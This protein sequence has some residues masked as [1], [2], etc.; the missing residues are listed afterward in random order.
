M[1]PVVAAA[2]LLIGAANARAI[3]VA[4]CRQIVPAGERAEL[5][6]NLVCGQ[7]SEAPFSARGV[8]LGAGAT[9]S[10][11]GHSILGDGT[12]VGVSCEP[13]ARRR[14]K[15]R[16]S[17]PGVIAGFE[18][19]I[20]GVGTLVVDGLVVRRNRF[21]IAVQKCCRLDV[22]NVL[23]E[24]NL[25]AGV[26]AIRLRGAGLHANGN[27]EVGVAATRFDLV[28]VQANANGIG[29]G[30]RGRG[31]LRNSTVLANGGFDGTYD[32]VALPRI[33]THGTTCGAGIRLRSLRVGA[34]EVTKVIG[35]FVCR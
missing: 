30:V 17:G 13:G 8:V 19:G 21:G 12:G 25:I 18:T 34:A 22:E 10:L 14:R 29:G 6:T 24:S 1:F 11:N 31:R 20:G 5:R 28:D 9:L 4:T 15:C 23:A 3:D 32:L 2:L 27:G 35:P 33:K 16:V 7:S 26:S